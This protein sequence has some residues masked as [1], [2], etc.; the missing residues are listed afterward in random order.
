MGTGAELSQTLIWAKYKKECSESSRSRTAR[1]AA[2][3]QGWLT[4]PS[5]SS[6]FLA[7][8][9][10]LG[11][12]LAHNSRVHLPKQSRSKGQQQQESPVTWG[13]E[14]SR[15]CRSRVWSSTLQSQHGVCSPRDKGVHTGC[16]N[17]TAGRPPT[18]SLWVCQVQSNK[19]SRD[20]TQP[21][22]PPLSSSSTSIEGDKF[23]R[24][25]RKFVLCARHAAFK[26]RLSWL[27]EGK[28]NH[29]S[30]EEKIPDVHMAMATHT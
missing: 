5:P 4:P 7:Q 17:P 29:S 13:T 28:E 21:R 15:P 23:I 8:K 24:V 16:H 6:S 25:N 18:P 12:S 20:S 30:L 11:S 27:W 19:N 22:N 3:T 10:T 2:Q 9:H 26:Q 1:L 14:G